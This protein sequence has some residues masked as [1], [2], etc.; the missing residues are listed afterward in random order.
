M[1]DFETQSM[2]KVFLNLNRGS[3]RAPA[4]ET[5][6]LLAMT[7]SF[8]VIDPTGSWDGK[9]CNDY[10]IQFGTVTTKVCSKSAVHGRKWLWQS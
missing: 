4:F 6:E 1:F 2:E 5:V 9:C 10:R 8:F 7:E 3:D